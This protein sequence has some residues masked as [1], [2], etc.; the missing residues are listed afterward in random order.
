MDSY[1]PIYDAVRSRISNGDIGYA[2]ESVLRE[3]SFSTY[4]DSACNEFKE[5][6]WE[7]GKPSAV[8]RPKLYPD[9]DMWCA[10]YGENLQEGIAGFGETPEKAMGDFDRRWR[11]ETLPSS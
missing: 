4:F 6:A 2:V 3:C 11:T 1:Q 10:L 8:Y 7:H 9:G 5:A